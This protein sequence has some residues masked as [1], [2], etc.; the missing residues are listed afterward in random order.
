MARTATNYLRLLQSLLPK[1]LIWN[2]E[3]GSTLTN[4]LLALAD[5]LS[6]VDGRSEDLLTESDPRVT[7]ELLTDFEKEYALPDDCF[8]PGKSIQQRRVDVFSRLI[9]VGQQDKNYFIELAAALGF[10]VTITE[11]TPFWCGFGGSGDECGEVTNIFQWR[12][13]YIVT[14]GGGFGRGFG[15]G[16]DIAENDLEAMQ[17]YL[18]KLKPAHTKL[19]FKQVGPAFGIGFGPGFDSVE[20]GSSANLQGGF[21]KGF[22]LGFDVRHGGAFGRGFGAGFDKPN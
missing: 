1:G 9:T 15:P 12:I 4:F 7:T 2:R 19:F 20:S 16:F 18:T 14:N 21:G 10:V 5:E 13:N 17:C 11:F 3:E 8:V 22:G 6:R